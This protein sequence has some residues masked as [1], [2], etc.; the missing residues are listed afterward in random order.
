[1]IYVERAF[2]R[3]RI[4]WFY[5]AILQAAF[6]AASVIIENGY[7]TFAI[8]YHPIK[9]DETENYEVGIQFMLVGNSL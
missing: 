2:N 4:F 3:T 7:S 1:M 6:E 9:W 5:L 8:F